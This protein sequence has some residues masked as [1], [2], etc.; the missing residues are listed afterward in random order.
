MTMQGF[1]SYAR[2]SMPLYDRICLGYARYRAPD[3][4]HRR[5]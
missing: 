4:P 3:P 5:C 1:V 2:G